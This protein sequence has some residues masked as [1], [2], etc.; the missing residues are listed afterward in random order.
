MTPLLFLGAII[1]GLFGGGFF[2]FCLWL[3]AKDAQRRYPELRISVPANAQNDP[4]FHIWCDASHYQQQPDGSYQS[5]QR[6]I[7]ANSGEIRFE[8]NEMIVYEVIDLGFARR[9]FALNAPLFSPAPSANA[10][11]ASSTNYSNIGKL[12]PWTMPSKP[13]PIFMLMRIR[14]WFS[15]CLLLFGKWVTPF[16]PAP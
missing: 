6:G 12:N 16:A 13:K 11:S 15:G 10:K 7:L 1:G 8:H 2:L 14:V 3:N 5:T 4:L 9:R